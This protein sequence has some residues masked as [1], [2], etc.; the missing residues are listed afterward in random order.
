MTAPRVILGRLLGATSVALTIVL[1]ILVLR[2]LDARPRTTDAMNAQKARALA[3][4]AK[5]QAFADALI[6][7][8]TLAFAAGELISAKAV[9]HSS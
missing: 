4:A 3:S 2:R 1:A 5:E 7:T 9:P 8:T 6:A